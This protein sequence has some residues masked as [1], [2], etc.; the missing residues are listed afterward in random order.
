MI[1]SEALCLQNLAIK[2]L[3]TRFFPC[4]KLENQ[5]LKHRRFKRGEV[6]MYTH[7]FGR[8]MV[9]ILMNL[10]SQLCVCIALRR[11]VYTFRVLQ[12]GRPSSLL[13]LT[14]GEIVY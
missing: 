14:Q 3:S 9:V 12:N 10:S 1:V 5:L 8:D 2:L 13:R 7:S 4:R 6:A 11:L